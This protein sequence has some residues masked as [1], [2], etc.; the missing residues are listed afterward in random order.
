MKSAGLRSYA[1]HGST[2]SMIPPRHSTHPGDSSACSATLR[3]LLVSLP[4]RRSWTHQASQSAQLRTPRLPLLHRQRLLALLAWSLC[5]LPSW[6]VQKLGCLRHLRGA[7]LPVG[8]S[9]FGAAFFVSK[10]GM[11]RRQSSAAG[12]ILLVPVARALAEDVAHSSIRAGRISVDITPA[13]LHWPMRRAASS[14]TGARPAG[15]FRS[16]PKAF[17]KRRT[18]RRQAGKRKSLFLGLPARAEWRGRMAYLGDGAAVARR[19]SLL[20]AARADGICEAMCFFQ[21]LTEFTSS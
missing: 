4:M 11:P 10:S 8:A 5:H 7:L 1:G 21:S 18:A 13:R 3:S 12:E 6:I 9:Y 15:T 17:S 14:K 19:V 16:A 20:M 2:V